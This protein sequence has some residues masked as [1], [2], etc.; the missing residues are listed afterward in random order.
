MSI[1][2]DAEHHVEYVHTQNGLIELFIKHL[3]LVTR[4]FLMRLKLLIS[5]WGHAIL[6]AT[7]IIH[8]RPITY[9]KYSPLQIGFW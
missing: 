5:C 3:Q 9:H 4:P 2:I 8:I 6:Y 1:G 7:S